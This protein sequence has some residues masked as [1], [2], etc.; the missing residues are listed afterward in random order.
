[1]SPFFIK[2]QL[3][4]QSDN[5]RF[6]CNSLWRRFFGF[7]DTQFINLWQKMLIK[8]IH[9]TQSMDEDRMSKWLLVKAS[10]P[11]PF[12]VNVSWC[13]RMLKNRPEGHPIYIRG[14]FFWQYVKH[15]KHI[16]KNSKNM[17]ICHSENTHDVLLIGK[18]ISLTWLTHV[19][20]DYFVG[21][22]LVLGPRSVS[23]KENKFTLSTLAKKSVDVIDICVYFL[24]VINTR[25]VCK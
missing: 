19:T 11:P 6:L 9:G 23:E 5:N 18:Q 1:M 15:L 16:K 8:L 17:Y 24:S 3:L 14:K 13:H 21:F 7:K 20:V 4:G 12:H 22:H 10:P 25:I 2:C